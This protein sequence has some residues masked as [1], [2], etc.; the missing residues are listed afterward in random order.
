[1]IVICKSLPKGFA[2]HKL[3]IGK[4]YDVSDGIIYGNKRSY[5]ILLRGIFPM[6]LI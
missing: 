5:C 6:S 3:T 4:E 1:M 2:R